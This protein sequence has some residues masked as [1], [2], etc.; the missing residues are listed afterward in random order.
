MYSPAEGQLW[1][2]L[3]ALRAATTNDTSNSF[4]EIPYVETLQFSL[5]SLKGALNL[6]CKFDAW[7]ALK[8]IVHNISSWREGKL[9]I[10]AD[11]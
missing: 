5:S 3:A 2:V 8:C 1:G 6:Q 10:A 7:R 4:W 9:Q 11:F